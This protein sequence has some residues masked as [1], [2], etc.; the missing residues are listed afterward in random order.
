MYLA[1]TNMRVLCWDE[2][3]SKAFVMEH[4]HSKELLIIGFTFF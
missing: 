4:K 1:R 2:L 3:T